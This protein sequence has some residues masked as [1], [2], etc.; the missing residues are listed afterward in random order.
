MLV[1]RQLR[2]CSIAGAAVTCLVAASAYAEQLPHARHDIF[3][4]KDTKNMSQNIT[5]QSA[6]TFDT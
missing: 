6:V 1:E 3:C 5:E 4:D 2:Y